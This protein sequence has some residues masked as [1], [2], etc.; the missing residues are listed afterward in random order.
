MS[1]SHSRISGYVTQIVLPR[2]I[3]LKENVIMWLEFD[4]TYLLATAP[5]LNERLSKYPMDKIKI[6]Q[7]HYNCPRI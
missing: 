3:S 2:D 4:P 6:N 5:T 7:T 1:I